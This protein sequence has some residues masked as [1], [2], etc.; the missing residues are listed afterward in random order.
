MCLAVKLLS[1]LNEHFSANARVLFQS[2]RIETPP[3][4]CALM[5]LCVFWAR[6]CLRPQIRSECTTFVL[7]RWNDLI[8][9]VIL[10]IVVISRWLA[11]VLLLLSTPSIVSTSNWPSG[12]G[13]SIALRTTVWSS[14]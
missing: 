1:L 11:V 8:R 4:T 7:E 12:F 10:I 6:E 13:I 3:A 2:Q 14:D 9:Y 5:Q